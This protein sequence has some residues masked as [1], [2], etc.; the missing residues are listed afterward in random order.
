MVLL[1]DAHNEWTWIKSKAKSFD[2]EKEACTAKEK[3]KTENHLIG[4]L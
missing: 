3:I 2:T 1:Q 4:I